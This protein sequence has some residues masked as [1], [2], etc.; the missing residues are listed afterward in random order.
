MST[1][2]P[3][4]Y[5][6]EAKYSLDDIEAFERQLVRLGAERG[7]VERQTDRYF[8]H[9]CR[10]FAQTDEACRIRSVGNASGTACENYLTYKGPLL[11]SQTKTRSEL[12]QRFA[13]GVESSQRLTQML[14]ILGF[15]EVPIIKKLR[16]HWHLCRAGRDFTIAIDTVEE[17]GSFVEIETLVEGN[18]WT[19][20][21]DSTLELAKQLD[22]HDSI[23]QS[24]LQ[25]LLEKRR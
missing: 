2:P 8:N 11:D 21:R 20:P 22:C 17:L 6:V 4:A 16:Q 10:D 12:E 13:D 18:D 3:E 7:T 1:H 9:P 15:R 24:Y 25:L 19:T 14:F 5:E 23:R